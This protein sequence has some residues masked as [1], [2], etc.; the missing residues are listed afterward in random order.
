MTLPRPV[1]P[2]EI[3]GMTPRQRYTHDRER[4]TTTSWGFIDQG[5]IVCTRDD[6]FA[7]VTQVAAHADAEGHKRVTGL[8]AY[9][10][11]G[12]RGPF[13]VQLPE[14]VLVRGDTHYIAPEL[15]REVR[16]AEA[17]A[18]SLA[19]LVK[20]MRADAKQY[21]R[22]AWHYLGGVQA[23]VEDFIRVPERAIYRERA[24]DAMQGFLDRAKAGQVGEP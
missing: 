4:W 18:A 14:S 20:Q 24:E 1:L 23:D 10:D 16:D 13:D 5:E 22:E 19:E 3:D 7:V 6:R 17:F 15:L 11:D 21:S 2:A 8:L 9:L 12:S